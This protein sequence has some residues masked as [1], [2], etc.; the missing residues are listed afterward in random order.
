[1]KLPSIFKPRLPKLPKLPGASK[2]S[3]LPGGSAIKSKRIFIVVAIWL[4][5]MFWM[6]TYGDDFE[7]LGA[8]PFSPSVRR[9]LITLITILSAMI[10]AV[11][12]LELSNRRLRMQQKQTKREVKDPVEMEVS[13]QQ[14]YL[15]RWMVNLQ[16]QLAVKNAEYKLPWYLVLGNRG[17]GKTTF[18]KEGCKL[19]E[20]YAPEN[21]QLVH[22]WLNN[23]AV[24]VEA[25]GV[26]LEQ[27]TDHALPT[28]YEKL[29]KNLLSWLVEVRPVQPL[30][31]IILTVDLYQFCTFNKIERENY[32]AALK[33]RLSEVSSTLHTSLPVYIVLTKFDL[34]YGFGAMYQALDKKQREEILGIT[35]PTDESD[36]KKTLNNFWQQWLHQLN[37]AMPGMMLNNVDVSQRS[38]LFTFIRQINGIKDYVQ[39]LIDHG[40]FS[41]EHN[42]F[43]LRGLYLTS[44]QQKG[45]MEDLFVKSA[46][47]QYNLP[48]QIYP[49]WQSQL[50]HPYFTHELLNNL[51][52]EETQLAGK[53]EQY[54]NDTRKRLY[55]WSASAAGIAVIFLAGWQYFYSYNHKAGDE[56]LANA[57]QYVEIELPDQKDYLGALQLPLLNPVSQATFAYGDY[58]KRSV[59]SDMGLY[60]GNKIGPYVES[61]YLNL[62]MQRF[63]PAIMNGLEQQLLKEKEGSDNKLR[64]LRIMRMIEDETGRDKTA[65]MNYMIDR[66]STA[67]KGQNDIQ[68]Q[69]EQHLSYALDHIDWKAER[70]NKNRLAIES[71][72][73]YEQSIK[74]AQVDLRRLS[75]Y[76]RVYQGLHGQAKTA[77]PNDLNIRNQVGASFDSIFVADNEALLKVPQL[78]TRSGLTN[79]FVLQDESLINYTSLDSWVLDI[80]QDVNYSKADREEIQKQITSLY[81]NDYITTWHNAY[82]NIHIRKFADIPDAIAGLEQITSGEYVFKRIMDLL[83]ENTN[84][85]ESVLGDGSKLLNTTATGQGRDYKLLNYLSHQFTKENSVTIEDKDQIS[86]LGNVSLKL[87]DLHR[88]LMA[89]QNSPSPGKSALQAVQLRLSNNNSDPIFE[90]Q[91]LSKSLPEP[92]GR[93]VNELATEVWNVIM[94]EAIRSLEVE[95]NDKV[96]TPYRQSLAQRYP[97]SPGAKLDVPLSEFERFFGYGGTLD[98][99]YQQNLKVFIDNEW[100]MNES[101]KSLIHPNILRQLDIAEKIRRTFFKKQNGLGI[102]FSIQPINMSGNRRRGILNLDG[103]LVEYRHSSSI[104]VRLIWP[105][106]M[107]DNV[108]SKL[109]L[110]GGERSNKT[111][112]YTSAWGLLRMINSGKLTNVSNNSFDVRYDIDNGYIIYRVFIDESDNPFAG[113]LFSQFNLPDTLY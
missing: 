96:V 35:F 22:C 3:K 86:A 17:S 80:T 59:L 104:P 32:I 92:L 75:I 84:P 13:V 74:D 24:I 77:L 100:S 87:T 52:F 97:F 65:V 33:A 76:R 11:L 28:L 111:L 54:R 36:W 67:F 88:Y 58:N 42:Q 72:L 81:L 105:N 5:A 27:P 102:Q 50:S 37:S 39:E 62:L 21:Q 103:Q 38:Q 31:G 34:L 7:I 101:D 113:G 46:A 2:L 30:S 57:K 56:V 83:R 25:D 66:W 12:H 73:P 19:N 8:K 51:L 45:Q 79:F 1:M 64:I 60:Q 14:R 93:W 6:W 82:N 49:S 90:A 4:L 23:Q 71:Y 48:E 20:L 110:V 47:S 44:S 95:W 99:F 18:L 40:L 29:W 16:K 91:Q 9:W 55:R 70:I 43:L 10:W 41:S 89:I 106:S 108:E 53:N 109:T 26:L 98:S 69:L 78:L 63:L 94:I 112:S 85:K 15:N 68:I 61:T 107:R